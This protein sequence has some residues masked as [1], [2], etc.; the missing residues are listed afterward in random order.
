LFCKLRHAPS[1]FLSEPR[2]K[3]FMW[4][5]TFMRQSSMVWWNMFDWQ[6]SIEWVLL[7]KQ[8]WF[9]HEDYQAG[10]SE[11]C[12]LAWCSLSVL[13]SSFWSYFG[14]NL[15]G[16]GRGCM[17]K[18]SRID[19]RCWRGNRLESYWVRARLFRPLKNSQAVPFRRAGTL[20]SI[21][22]ECF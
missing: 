7:I 5:R 22:W 16:N 10:Y 6:S 12:V 1:K 14:H 20:N 11:W 19:F 15:R 4:I 8:I 13:S 18:N 17:P 21:L 3:L 9:P 2:D